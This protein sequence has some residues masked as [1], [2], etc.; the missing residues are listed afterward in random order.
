MSSAHAPAVQDPTP[1][2]PQPAGDA[3]LVGE[4]PLAERSL[5]A[6]DDAPPLISASSGGVLLLTLN[7]PRH[8]NPLSEEMLAAL[9]SALDAAATEPAVRVVVLGATGKVFCAGH[10]LR[11][12]RQKPRRDYYQWLFAECARLMRRIRTLPQPVI[13]RVQGAATA[14]G[15][16]LVASCDLAV[17][18][19]SARFATSG[20]NIGLFCATPAV[21]LSRNIGRKA[22]FEMLVTGEFIDAA[23]ALAQGLLNYVV[24]EVGLDAAVE[25]LVLS[26]LAKPAAVV[27]AGKALFY[28]QQEMGMDAAYQLAVQA[29]TCNL[30]EPAAQEGIA[31]FLDKRPP[32]WL[33]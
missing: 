31:A 26:I 8:C 3:V 17:A 27:A 18:V 28:R 12:I 1:C 14:A 10:D 21:P 7:R 22:A 4:F 19:D 20:V 24:P 30:L 6:A 2:R 5:P 25:R 11:Q 29:M 32:H 13:A 33:A 16:Q 15:C 23:T 9:S